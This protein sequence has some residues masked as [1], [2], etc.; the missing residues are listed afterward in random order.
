VFPLALNAHR[1]RRRAVPAR[2]VGGNGAALER[3]DAW[4]AA[5]L[6]MNHPPAL[7]ARAVLEGCAF[8]LRDIVDRTGRTRSRSRRSAHRR[9]WCA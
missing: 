9:R 6:A 1:Q 3:P 4:W 2:A 7:V 8:A 5:R